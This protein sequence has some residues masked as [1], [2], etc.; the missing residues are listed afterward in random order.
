RAGAGAG[1][2]GEEQAG[3]GPC[4]PEAAFVPLEHAVL[5][6]TKEEGV[7]VEA[8]DGQAKKMYVPVASSREAIVLL[9]RR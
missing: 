2:A 9:A 7:L 6:L 8:V 5:E 3:A 4:H 1:G